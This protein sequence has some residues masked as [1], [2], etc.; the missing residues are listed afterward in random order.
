[1]DLSTIKTIGTG[2]L[3]PEGVMAL[4]GGILYTADAM[5]RCS[6]IDENGNT[7]FWG[8]VGGTP[9]GICIDTRGNCII[10]NIGNGQVQSLSP[11]GTH[12]VLFTKAEAREMPAPNFPYM[13]SKGRLWVSN[14]TE[15]ESLDTALTS[16]LPDGCVIVYEKGQARI[17]TE[18]IY[19]ANGLTLDNNEE[20]LYVAQT[21]KRNVLRYKVSPDG[22][23]GPA[24]IYGPKTL[25][26]L[27]F[28]DGI[29]FDDAANL[30]VTFPAWNA[31][32]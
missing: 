25:G 1:M 19:F 20:Y 24:E 15:S 27:G 11:D 22:S 8:D 26:D 16:P 18:G 21:V 13:D 17:V 6:R 29:A 5:G 10:A 14:S 23:L 2:I 9:N 7:T 3:R 4:D 32:G 31:V 30:W 12:E 28:L